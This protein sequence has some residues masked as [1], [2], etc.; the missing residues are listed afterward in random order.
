MTTYSI[1]RILFL[2]SITIVVI[3]SIGFLSTSIFCAARP[4]FDAKE[5]ED[6]QLSIQ[7][8]IKELRIEIAEALSEELNQN[9]KIDKLNEKMDVLENE[10]ANLNPQAVQNINFWSSKTWFNNYNYRITVNLAFTLIG[11]SLLKI[12]VGWF[13]KKFIKKEKKAFIRI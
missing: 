9:N 2:T 10:I 7:E 11:L 1:K 4:T 3:V 5:I 13:Y 12:T 8:Q 6:S